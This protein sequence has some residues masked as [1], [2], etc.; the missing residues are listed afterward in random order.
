MR[1]FVAREI[2]PHVDAW[3]EAGSFPRELYRK[4]AAVGL[5]G[6]GYP[7]E[8]GGT[9]ADLFFSIVAAEE[10]A[11]AGCGGLQASLGSH[12]IGCRRSWRTAAR[13]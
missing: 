11:R 1:A 2:T 7:E 5:L 8:F 4:A 3:D 13:R 12:H 6:I 9:P 10:M